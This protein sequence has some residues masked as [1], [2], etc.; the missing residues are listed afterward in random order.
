[1]EFVLSIDRQRPR[2]ISVGIWAT[3]VNLLRAVSVFHKR[4]DLLQV[5]LKRL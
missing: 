4:P 1:M 2:D 3:G 5:N